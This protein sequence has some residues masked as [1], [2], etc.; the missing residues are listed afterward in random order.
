[1][2]NLFRASSILEGLS[3]LV[4]LS[5]TLGLIPREYVFVLGMG[6]GFLFLLY[7]ALSLVV[8]HKQ[9]WS[10]IIWLLVLLAAVIPFAFVPVEL[11]LK[12]EQHKVSSV[13]P[14]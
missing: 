3:Y 8:S 10:V 2:L 11:F 5:V 9:Q 14:S 7:F 1:M 6:H 4:I 12:K 13:N